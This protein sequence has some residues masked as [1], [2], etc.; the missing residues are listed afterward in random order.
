VTAHLYAG[1]CPDQLQPDARD[2]LCPACYPA[3]TGVACPTCDAPVD[4]RCTLT[5]GPLAGVAPATDPHVARHEA[6][7]DLASA[8]T[9]A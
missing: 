1:E 7:A 3:A 8:A 5:R 9:S 6:L 4:V 2:P